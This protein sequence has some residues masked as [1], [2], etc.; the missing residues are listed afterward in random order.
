[1]EGVI[2]AENYLGDDGKIY[3]F[4]VRGTDEEGYPE[5]LI[6]AKDVG[7]R[8]TFARQSVKPFIGMRV[9]FDVSINGF[10]YNYKILK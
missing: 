7:G 8:G 3:T 10:G 9:Q 4:D 5:I 2:Q 1:M 6:D